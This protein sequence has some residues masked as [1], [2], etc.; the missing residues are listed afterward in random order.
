MENQNLG[1]GSVP[2]QPWGEL[3]TPQEALKMGTVFKDMNK[4]FFADKVPVEA[5]TV[6]PDLSTKPAQQEDREC[7]LNKIAE[8]S[9]ILDDLTLFLDTHSED[10]HAINLYDEYSKLRAELKTEFAQKHYP[11]TRDCMAGGGAGQSDFS[12]EKGPIPWEGACV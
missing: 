8:A 5:P 7:L 10:Q 6:M 9:F 4:P 2:C 1:I 3:Y 11:L 12:W